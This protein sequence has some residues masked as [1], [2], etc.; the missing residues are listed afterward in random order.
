MD[1]VGNIPIYLAI[2]KE[3]PSQR[4]FWI[5]FREKI[6]ALVI[7]LLFAIFGDGFLPALSISHEAI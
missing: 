1:P 5:I 3:L 6:I 4:R 2:L 7:I